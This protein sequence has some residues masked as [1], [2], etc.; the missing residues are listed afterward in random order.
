MLDELDDLLEL[1]K[2]VLLELDE[3]TLE[4]ELENINLSSNHSIKT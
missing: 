1:E 3:L 2:L 4:L